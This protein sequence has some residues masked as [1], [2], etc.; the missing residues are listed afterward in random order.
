[1]KFLVCIFLL[2]KILSATEL[3]TSGNIE[4]T[5]VNNGDLSTTLLEA[6]INND[7]YFNNTK[8][9][10]SVGIFISDNESYNN[11][12]KEYVDRVEIYRVN[13]L[14]LTQYLTDRLS[15]SF[16]VFPFKKGTFYEYG[17]N[18][19]R[20]G[21]GLYTL[22]DANLQGAIATYTVDNH[23]LQI[24]SV[25]YEKYIST[26][27]DAKEGNGNI[28]FRSY[29]DSGM[30]YISY[31]YN[32]DKWYSE[33][34]LT[35]TFQYLNDVKII[36]TD[37]YSLALSY[38]D[39]AITGRT[40]Y[41]ILTMTDSVGDN[42]SLSPIGR[43]S[44]D[45]Y[46]FDK[47]E[48]NGYSWLLG[49]K[50]EIDNLIFNKDFVFGIEYLYRSEGYHSL[51]AGEPLSYDSYSNIGSSYNTFIGMRYDKNTMFK[52]RYY[53]YDSHDRMTKGVL[54]PVSTDLVNKDGNGDYNS[55]IL[56][57]YIDF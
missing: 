40:Y 4:T 44:T 12:V 31:K 22:S 8:I 37:T 26:Y 46:H 15:V 23:T 34:M 29:K 9:G 36:S 18:G 55:I 27:Y 11:N 49:F 14:Y 17:Y 53:R 7:L 24:G 28:T 39:E 3:K 56:Q 51:L 45:E 43:F 33:I 5:N 25:A 38:D 41:S 1:M 20:T 42:S 30:N 52:L 16:G 57:L 48:T 10:T 35:N 19:N 47:F 13:E 6:N 32:R 2:V 50:Q 21:I 54:S